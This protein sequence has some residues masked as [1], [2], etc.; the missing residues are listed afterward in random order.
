[1]QLLGK[2]MHRHFLHEAILGECLLWNPQQSAW[3]WTDIEASAVYRLRKNDVMPT[4][5]LTPDRVGSFAHG[6]SG[7]LLLGSVN[8]LTS[9]QIDNGAMLFSDLCQ[10]EADQNRTRINDGRTDRRGFFVFGTFDQDSPKQA[11]GSFYQ[12]SMQH[13][14]R[15]LA[16]PKVA[17]PNSICF[18]LDGKTMYFADTLAGVIQR[19]DYDAESAMVS[20]VRFFAKPSHPQASPDGSVIDR[21]GCLW[22]AQWGAARVVQYSP[23]GIEMRVIEVPVKNPTCPAFGGAK[24]DQLMV[25]SSRKDMS[26]EELFKMPDAGSLFC[27]TLE[28]A[29]G[30]PEVLFD[31]EISD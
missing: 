24:L 4:R 3:W 29:L 8:S 10:V 16:L 6:R 19:C 1:M 23:D 25:T 14:L 11:I 13:G 15:R 7:K 17:I 31:D 2:F 20:N 26:E 21:N 28:D 18:S 30:V 9:M 12:F 5:Y 27:I 22:N